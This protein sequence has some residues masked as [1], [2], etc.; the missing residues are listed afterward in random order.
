[1]ILCSLIETFTSLHDRSA[2]HYTN[3]HSWIHGGAQL[4]IKHVK[5]KQICLSYKIFDN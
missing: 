3:T 2:S 4:H 1:M 5:V